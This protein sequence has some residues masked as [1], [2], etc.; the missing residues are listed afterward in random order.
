MVISV[1]GDLPSSYG[2]R[3]GTVLNAT[4]QY[5]E[6]LSELISFDEENIKISYKDMPNM[7]DFSFCLRHQ[8]LGWAV[9]RTICEVHRMDCEL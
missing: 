9:V 7:T 5:Q 6:R 3:I 2:D 1:S 4:S 8:Y